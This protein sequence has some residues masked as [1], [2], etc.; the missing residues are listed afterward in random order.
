MAIFTPTARWQPAFQRFGAQPL[1]G[2]LLP[3]VERA[4][5][6]PLFGCRMCGNCLLQETAF[7]C[8]MECPKG[9]RN[10]PCG[11]S[12]ELCYVDPS[13]TRAC[14]WYAIYERAIRMGREEMLMEVLPPVD[15]GQV[16]DETW[17]DVVRQVGEV[18]VQNW[19]RGLASGQTRSEAWQSVFRPVRQPE[20]WAGD[21]EYHAPGYTDP[22][23]EL[24]RRLRAGEFVAT[25]EI[26]QPLGTN[27]APMLDR[28]E[29]LK[30]W[31][32]AANF[33][34]GA[35]A[36]S[37]MSSLGAAMLALKAGME[38]VLQIASRDVNRISLQNQVVGAVANGVRNVFT[39]TGDSAMLSR[40]PKARLDWHDLDAVQML[41]TLRRLRDEG[42]FLGGQKVP[43]PPQFFL[44]AAA[45]PFSST[46]QIQ[47][48]REHKKINAGAQFLQTQ[49]VFDL[50]A[51]DRWL[52]AI[53][54]RGVLDKVHILAGVCPVR[55]IEAAR[56]MNDN[57]P[58]IIIPPKIMQRL[59]DAGDGIAEVGYQ[60]ALEALEHFRQ[61]SGIAGVHIMP[62]GWNDVA[63]RLMVD[64]G[65]APVSAA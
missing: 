12:T 33:T 32:V 61:A 52:E 8:P 58:G 19:A 29:H 34:E 13:G 11:G 1:V 21:A 24:E 39:I 49:V 14:V 30:Q 48:L 64:A 5:K 4:V 17:A 20:W 50:E 54:R 60:I 44:G 31:C 53:D 23:S 46:P 51:F 42:I 10:G 2:R 45:S 57:V 7:I 41:W 22:V 65:I 18:G 26:A 37:R 43:E 62:M 9:L 47:A 38:P 59:E 6:G 40:T 55:S 28:V 25:V 36:S 16:G 15:W 3:L 63:S 56:H 35:S 27:T